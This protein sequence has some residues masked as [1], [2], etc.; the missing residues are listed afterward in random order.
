MSGYKRKGLPKRYRLY[1]KY[2]RAL[3]TEINRFVAGGDTDGGEQVQREPQDIAQAVTFSSSEE[4]EDYQRN[5]RPKRPSKKRPMDMMSSTTNSEPSSPQPGTSRAAMPPPVQD[6]VLDNPD[7]GE[8]GDLNLDISDV[9]K[10][11]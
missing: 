1:D 9:V 10:P 6:S 7:A 3:D 8:A 2:S 11:P 4:E 5:Y